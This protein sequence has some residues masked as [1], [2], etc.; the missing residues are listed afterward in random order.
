[1]EGYEFPGT[2]QF[3]DNFRAHGVNPSLRG[4]RIFSVLA[5]DYTNAAADEQ[6]HKQAHQLEVFPCGCL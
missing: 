4:I 5:M 3:G 6:D 1:V 2:D